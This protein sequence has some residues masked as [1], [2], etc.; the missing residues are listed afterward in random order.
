M[1]GTSASSTI[2]YGALELT[3]KH[4]IDSNW[5]LVIYVPKVAFRVGSVTPNADGSPIVLPVTLE[6]AKPSSGDHVQPTLLN[7]VSASYD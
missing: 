1:A 3:A 5:S 2:V 6:V 7:G 4:S